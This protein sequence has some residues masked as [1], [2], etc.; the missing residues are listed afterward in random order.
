[1]TRPARA[2]LCPHDLNPAWCADCTPSAAATPAGA[3]TAVARHDGTCPR[4]QGPIWAGELIVLADDTWICADCY[5]GG[6]L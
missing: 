2:R 4:C 5:Q 1:M 3:V 6:P